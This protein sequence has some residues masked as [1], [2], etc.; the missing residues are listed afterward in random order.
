MKLKW[1]LLIVIA[2]AQVCAAAEETN[3]PNAEIEALKK[4]VQALE[5][6][7]E[8]LEQQQAAQQNVAT[9]PVESARVEELDQKVKILERQR[10]SDQEQAEAA[11]KTAPKFSADANGFKISSADTNFVIQLKGLVQLDSRTFFEDGGI[12]DNDGF[13][14]RRA[15]P[16][17]QG[18]VYRDFDFAFVPDFGGS[19]VQILDAYI[20]YRFR[21]ELQLE[22]GKFKSPVG[23]EALESDTVTAFN[24]RSMVTDLVPNRDL[25]VELHGDLFSGS[26][27]YAL[28]IFDGAPDFSGSVPNLDYD[29]NKALA[30][31]V[32]LQP[33]RTT[34]ISTLQGLGFGVGG[35]WEVDRSSSSA[36]GTGLTPGYTTDGQQ[37]FF[38]YNSGVYADGE[39]W[40]ISPQAY[41]YWKSFGILGEYVYSDLGVTKGNASANLNNTAWEV[42]G[43]W[44]LTGENAS[45][46]GFTPA[47]PFDPHK[48]QWGAWQLVARY[49]TVDI[50]KKAFP[51]FSNPG[52]SAS[53]AHE[54]AVG[55]NWFLN[56][57]LRVNASFSHTQFVDGN[58]GAV[59]KQP[60]NVLFTRVQL[61]F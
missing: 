14:L 35:S 43:S 4:E 8:R 11:A 22:I 13:I 32:F 16:I 51:I 10:E 25:G 33:F 52:T 6:K 45:Y 31:R 27:N 20:N 55:V 7:I 53:A 56:K 21:P 17:L 39:H 18:T 19:T 23:L 29:D 36:S 44:I 24:E 40:R 28:G 3:S 58:S 48:N 12:K 54:W 46:T 37:K 59:T 49:S 47:R 2:G 30:A 9:Q 41:Y 57:N 61:A 1:W 38:T 50:D 5:R 60:E 15:R 42:T 34:D 26:L